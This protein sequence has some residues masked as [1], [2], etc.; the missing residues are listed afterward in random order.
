MLIYFHQGNFWNASLEKLI[1]LIENHIFE[2][3]KNGN[4]IKFQQLLVCW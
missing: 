1:I 3:I 4:T 2:G